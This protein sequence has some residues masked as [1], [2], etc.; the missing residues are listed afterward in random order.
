MFFFA[1]DIS[2]VEVIF[3]PS[4]VIDLFSDNFY[5]LHTLAQALKM[6][7]GREARILITVR[8]TNIDATIWFHLK[9]SSEI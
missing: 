1:N 4:V 3:D 8:L 9:N 5:T 2:D 6:I 7:A